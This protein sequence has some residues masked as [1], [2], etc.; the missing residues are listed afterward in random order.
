MLDSNGLV[1]QL[2][3]QGWFYQQNVL[4]PALISG[5]ADLCHSRTFLQ[6]G[7][8]RGVKNIINE[9]IRSDSISWIEKSETDP[10]ISRYLTL[11]EQ[12]RQLLNREFFLGLQDFEGHFSRYPAGAYYKPHYDCFANDK[13]RA[14]TF[15]VYI[16]QNW[17]PQDG[18]ELCLHLPEGERLI[19]PVAGSVLCFLSEQILH[20]VKPTR[21][22]RMALTGWFIR[23]GGQDYYYS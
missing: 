20:E 21:K 18:G 4:D 15:I 19:Q 6:A 17:H 11:V 12:T 7:I 13:R 5:L 23:N 9:S 8:G 10:A 3:D 16:N 14:V 22:E 1:K 2:C